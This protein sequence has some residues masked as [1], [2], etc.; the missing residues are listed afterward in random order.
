MC[1]SGTFLIESAYK[2]LN[3]APGLRR[4]FAAQS[5]EQIPQEIW[6]DVRTEAMAA[7]DRQ[8]VSKHLALMWT[9]W[10]WS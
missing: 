10:R 9:I 7:I 4:N 3:V 8:E 5:W 2:A 6:Q 1:G